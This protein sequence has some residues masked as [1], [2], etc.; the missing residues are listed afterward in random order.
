MQ[1]RNLFSKL[2]YGFMSGRSTTLQLLYVLDNWIQ[3]IN[4]GGTVYC[5]FFDFMKAF[6]SVPYK[7]LLLKLKACG[8]DGKLLGWIEMFLLNRW[9]RVVING[10]ASA[11]QWNPTGVCTRSIV[12]YINDLLDAIKSQIYMFADDT[13]IYR[14]ISHGSDNGVLQANL[15]CLQ[16]W[17]EKM[18]DSFS[19][20]QMQV[21][22][23]WKIE[24]IHRVQNE[25]AVMAYSPLIKSSV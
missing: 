25:E 1:T 13:K 20:T 17:S 4:L 23:T 7:I 16:D 9:Q 5:I 6:D 15:D 11:G 22:G 19:F 3:K 24:N 18:A 10:S 12:I 14:H 2:Q 21:H 8:I